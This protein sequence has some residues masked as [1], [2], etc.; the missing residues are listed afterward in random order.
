MDIK[1]PEFVAALGG[2]M[3]IRHDSFARTQVVSADALGRALACEPVPGG[4]D[5]GFA[6]QS[7]PG[8]VFHLDAC[9]RLPARPGTTIHPKTA[10]LHWTSI[11][12]SV[13]R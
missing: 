9:G 8:L 7:L 11:A 6:S 2:L 12:V 10:G 3:N 4:A 5:P 1:S 13:R